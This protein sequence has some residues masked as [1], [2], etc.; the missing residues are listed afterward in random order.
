[1]LKYMREIIKDLKAKLQGELVVDVASRRFFSTDGSIFE[2]TPEWI[3]YPR[4][5]KD[6]SEVMRRLNQLASAGKSIPITAR[7][8]GTDQGGAALSE[9]VSL[10]FPA[11]V[12]FSLFR[13]PAL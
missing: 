8:K 12:S 5:E 4:N 10:V 11:G 3:V 13:L 7:G 9:G 6:V 2:V 1:M